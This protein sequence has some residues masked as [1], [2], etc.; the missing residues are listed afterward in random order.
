MEAVLIAGCP[1]PNP[2]MK[3]F[4]SS[5]F[6]GAA[7][8]AVAAP[9]L[10]KTAPDLSCMKTAIAVRE[11]V[12]QKAFTAYTQSIN[13]SL[14]KRATD[15]A[16]AWDLTETASRRAA[17]KSAWV[18]FRTT[19]QTAKKMYVKSRNALWATFKS[20]SKACHLPTGEEPSNESLDVQP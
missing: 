17:I 13:T 16:A 6:L 4:F 18:S 3:R 2:F 5:L 9:A 10:A 20:S 12:V 7:V 15:L 14:A 8:L 1:F 11:A 19:K